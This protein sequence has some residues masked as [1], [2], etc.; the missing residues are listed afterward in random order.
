MTN[1]KVVPV[2]PKTGVSLV[3]HKAA[4]K[5]LA[6]QRLAQGNPLLNALLKRAEAPQLRRPG[7]GDVDD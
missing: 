6:R 7:E 1:A 5:P 3:Y 4:Q 2:D